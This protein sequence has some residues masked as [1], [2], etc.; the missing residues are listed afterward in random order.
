MDTSGISSLHK[1][2]AS[3]HTTDSQVLSGNLPNWQ[4]DII[5]K[6]VESD[7]ALNILLEEIGKA[8]EDLHY[9]HPAPPLPKNSRK[10]LLEEYDVKLELPVVSFF[11]GAGGLDLGLE[12]IGCKHLALV[13]HNELFCST[14]RHNRPDWNVIGPP[15]NLGDVSQP[16]MIAEELIKSSVSEMFEGLFV[17]GPP[18]QPFSIASNQRFSRDSGKFKRVGYTHKS[19]GT[20]LADYVTLIELF[21]PAAFLV[22]NVTGLAEVDGGVQFEEIVSRLRSAGYAVWE[23]FIVD[24]A[25]F[26]VPQSRKRLFLTGSRLKG[27]KR[28]ELTANDFLVPCGSVLSEIKDVLNS[29]TRLHKAKSIARYMQLHCGQRDKLGRCDRLDPSKPSKTVIAGG[30]GGGGRS[31][32]HPHIPRT[33]SVRECARLQTFPDNY[34]FLGPSARQFTQV[35]NAVPPLLAAQLGIAIANSLP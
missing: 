18:C 24:A 23:P 7:V 4:T 9:E 28:P 31:H 15:N 10:V 25:H 22:E 8:Y 32:L 5:A 3:V 6:A 33:M 21:K 20:L 16:D 1:Q 13:E 30:T 34:E 19:N 35:G 26:G 12:A 17:G 14:L 27:A 11:S 29:E 2:E